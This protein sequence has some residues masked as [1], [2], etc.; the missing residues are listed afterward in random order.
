[1]LFTGAHQQLVLMTL[2][3]GEEL[4][5]EVH[6]GVDQFFR[7]EL[8][9]GEMVINGNAAPV[10]EGWAVVVPAGM[11]HTLRNT[12]TQRMRL[13]TLYAPPVHAAG[14]VHATKAAS[15]AV[16]AVEEAGVR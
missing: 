2:Q 8:G 4:G 13:T 7:I 5:E 9:S 6:M 16:E 3:P 1:V 15:E 11:R 12:G 10:S 14:T